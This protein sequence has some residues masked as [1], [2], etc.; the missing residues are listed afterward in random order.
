M[1][2]K[3]LFERFLP[4]QPGIPFKQMFRVPIGASLSLMFI[5]LVG[6]GFHQT[7]SLSLWL[8]P[9]IAASALLVFGYPENSE[10]QPWAIVMGYLVCSVI[11]VTCTR[12]ITNPMILFP[13]SIGLCVFVMICLNC[14]H[15]PAAALALFF[16]LMHMKDYSF[17]L[18]PVLIDAVLLVVF[19][20]I[21]NN[22]TQVP[23]P[24]K[25]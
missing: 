19:A 25:K 21:Y 24:P 7:H 14:V 17:I 12:Y 6:L 11:A 15:P 8:I 22:L 2:I 20:L 3:L 4:G 10:A 9:P 16:P 23:Y 13:L 1:N 18:E 5:F